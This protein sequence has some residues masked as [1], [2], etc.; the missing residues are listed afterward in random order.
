MR[1]LRFFTILQ[2]S[3]IITIICVSCAS[4]QTREHLADI[5]SYIDSRPDSALAAIRQI[6]TADLRGRAVKAKYALLHAIA[7]DK[8]YIDT[9]DTRIVQP[10]VE[11]YDRHGS[12]EE[13]LKAN[14]YLGTEQYNAGQFNQAIVSFSQAAEFAESV[15]D[16]NLLGILYSRMADTFAKT[17]DY[18]LAESLINKSIL[19][20]QACERKDQER[21]ERLRQAKLLT[22]M[23]RWKDADSCY[24][25]LL[26]ETGG[27]VEF[28]H[29][30]EIDYALFL[31]VSPTQNESKALAYL[32][33]NKDCISSRANTN[34]MGAY[35]YALF[36]SGRKAQSDLIMR[37]LS[38][39]S[40]DDVYY[41]YWSHRI[42]SK[43]GDFKKAYHLLWEAQQVS[44]SLRVIAQGKS[45][46]VAEKE[47]MEQS[48]DNSQLR[49]K[50]GRLINCLIIML[51]ATLLLVSFLFLR[52]RQLKNFEELEKMNSII[53]SLENQLIEMSDKNK[54]N[55]SRIS[56]L[57][58]D[59]TKA[60]F[61]YLSEL[62]EILY[63][64]SNELD[65]NS[66]RSTYKA[67]KVRV[68]NLDSDE[69][70]KR[71]FEEMLNE[72]S[73]NIMARF[74]KDFP[75]LPE[76]TMRLAC[77]VF[78]GFDNTT[79]SLLLGTSSSNTRTLKFRLMKQI[80]ASN[81]NN[82]GD[83]LVYFSKK[84]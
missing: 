15:E 40:K 30:A 7:L 48:I 2:A 32:E 42:S 37:Q 53:G 66:L 69:K 61:A 27:D 16:Q 18:M 73:D 78:A 76:E 70:S 20:F 50:G 77:L 8:N 72:E 22:Q 9:A 67:I 19:C 21:W 82:K 54:D 14:M 39:V 24:N 28:N 84:Q 29:N 5:E 10:A 12:P 35:A 45:A 33:N 46:A 47:F 74:R 79:L 56:N 23:R 64:N 83:Y 62:F 34:I 75:H 59:K 57:V 52:N 41:N 60:R 31:L 1:S 13:K 63:H 17:K 25:A 51:V 71:H 11:W 43:E 36:A 6:D 26:S 81:S 58:R 49:I 38:S 65:V 3:I 4:R 80:S 44:D 68:S 55:E